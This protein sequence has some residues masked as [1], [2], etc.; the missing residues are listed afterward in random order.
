MRIIWTDKGRGEGGGIIFLNIDIKYLY[1][2][3]HRSVVYTCKEYYP[4]TISISRVQSVFRS[5]QSIQLLYYTILY[6]EY[7]IWI[8]NR[9]LSDYCFQED[10]ICYLFSDLPWMGLF[11]GLREYPGARIILSLKHAL[12]YQSWNQ[13]IN[14]SSIL[15]SW[16]VLRTHG[17]VQWDLELQS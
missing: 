11:I 8:L 12:W 3:H 13:S 16:T 4:K 6:I 7:K 1:R 2:V 10:G 9:T 5:I 17:S 15:R 14:H